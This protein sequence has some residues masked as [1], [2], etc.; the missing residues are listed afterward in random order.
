MPFIHFVDGV[1]FAILFMRSAYVIFREP[2]DLS[3][4]VVQHLNVSAPHFTKLNKVTRIID[5]NVSHF[6]TNEVINAELDVTQEN[7]TD[8][9]Y[10][11]ITGIPELHFDPSFDTFSSKAQ[12]FIHHD[13]FFTTHGLLVDE[14]GMYTRSTHC[15]PTLY[16]FSLDNIEMYQSVIL[17]THEFSHVFGHWMT[18]T[19]PVLLSI[20]KPILAT[21]YIALPEIPEFLKEHLS[22]IDVDVSQ[23]IADKKKLFFAKTLVTIGINLCTSPNGTYV[24]NMKN[25]LMKKLGLKSDSHPTTYA[26][27]ERKG[28]NRNILNMNDLVDECRSAFPRHKWVLCSMPHSIRQAAALVST[29]CFMFSVHSSALSNMIFMNDGSIVVELGVGSGMTNFLVFGHYARLQYFYGYD[30]TLPIHTRA[31]FL[32]NVSQ[33]IEL[34]GSALSER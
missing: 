25:C 21:S 16:D 34:I 33:C 14:D 5:A 13:V 32:V 10:T 3:F 31:S 26:I 20:P 18:E 27:L 22:L 17:V 11:N 7:I 12:F 15:V 28:G 2:V 9:V 6:I 24:L 30:S 19:L 1:V 23:F 29:F 4:Q 8:V